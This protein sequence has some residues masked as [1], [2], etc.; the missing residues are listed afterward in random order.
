MRARGGRSRAIRAHAASP[1][2]CR[3]RTSVARPGL[4]VGSATVRSVVLLRRA[5]KVSLQW[6]G[7]KNRRR[8]AA[9]VEA[10]RAAVN[11]FIRLLWRD[12][13]AGF[14]T[15]TSKQLV[16]TRLSARYRDQALKQAVESVKGTRASA[17][18]PFAREM[19]TRA[20]RPYF[21]GSAVLDAKF[22]QRI[23]RCPT[24]EHDLVVTLSCLTKGKPLRLRTRATRVLNR[25]LKAPGARLVVGCALGHG[26]WL[27]LWVEFPAPE[28]HVTGRVL[29][30]D[31]GVN[32]L[33]ATSDEQVLGGGFRQVRD[34]IRRRRPGS[35]GRR[36]ARRERDQLICEATKQ[37][38]WSEV[39]AVA[40]EDLRGIKRG[41][42]PGQGRSFRRRLAPWRAGFV[43][44]RL[45]C[46]AAERGVLAIPVPAWRNSTTCPQCR[47][48]SRRNRHGERFCCLRCGFSADADVVGARAA[49]VRGAA[50]LPEAFEDWQ[51]RCVEAAAQRTRRHEAA[52]RRG[53]AT[54]EARRRERAAAPRAGGAASLG[55][56]AAGRR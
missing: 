42:R 13:T 36:R 18:V 31:V 14:C 39:S 47:H 34:K 17:R 24:A 54:A 21:R 20:G 23:E 45:E 11:F 8:L 2:A 29:G 52:Q 27:T 33:L 15:A 7:P 51:R 30:V 16:R 35:K 37:L 19:G 28:K 9:L 12:P 46:L 6:V 10:Y 26:D 50:R 32:K 1:R 49:S 48:W 3:H 53:L 4:S 38:P 22:V 25:W 44:Q 41:K 55:G 5:V 43:E 40:F 56:G